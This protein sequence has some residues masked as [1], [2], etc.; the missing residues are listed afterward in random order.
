MRGCE[1]PLIDAQELAGFT[2][3]AVAL[4]GALGTSQGRQALEVP[5]GRNSEGAVP[6]CHATAVNSPRFAHQP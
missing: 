4:K 2:T 5:S 6:H 3:M 1:P